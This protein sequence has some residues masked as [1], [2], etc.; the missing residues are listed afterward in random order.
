M[1]CSG[2]R[3]CISACA[4]L[5]SEAGLQPVVIQ[6]EVLDDDLAARIGGLAIM[7]GIAV[8][9]LSAGFAGVVAWFFKEPRV[10]L[11]VMALSA[12]FV[13]RGAQVLPRGLLAR[14]LDFR[15][16]SWID[17]AESMVA[18]FATVICAVMGLSYWSLVLGALCGISVSTTLCYIM[19]PHRITL[20]RGRFI[21]LPAP[22]KL[23]RPRDGVA[24]CLVRL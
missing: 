1:D 12:T 19:R 21:R 10:R 22:L 9:A 7:T 5:A 23:G 14:D 3:W 4:Q 20:P 15:R 16:L 24:V 8:C 13:L 11:L 17:G 2:W 6:P 18:A